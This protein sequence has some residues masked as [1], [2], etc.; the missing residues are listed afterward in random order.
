M[1]PAVI[2]DDDDILRRRNIEA[3]LII[4]DVKMVDHECLRNGYRFGMTIKASAHA[5]S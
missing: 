3:L 2:F 4:G 5:L 1:P